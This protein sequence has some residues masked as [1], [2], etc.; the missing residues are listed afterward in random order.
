M[1]TK[2]AK[3]VGNKST[4]LIL[5]SASQKLNTGIKSLQEVVGQL[6][7]MDA[8]IEEKTLKLSNMDNEIADLSVRKQQ[9]IEQQKFEI[10]LAYKQNSRTFVDDFLMKNGLEV[11]S[12]D[13]ILDLRK[14]IAE[15]DQ[16]IKAEVAKEVAIRTKQMEAD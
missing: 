12:R 11:I 4:E 3:P 16:T 9:E 6:T 15:R 5:G 7:N 8:L 1:A 2:T 14:A 10:E 13:E